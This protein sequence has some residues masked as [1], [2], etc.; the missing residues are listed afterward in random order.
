MHIVEA[1]CHTA[2]TALVFASQLCPRVHESAEQILRSSPCHTAAEVAHPAYAATG[3]QRGCTDYVASELDGL[4]RSGDLGRLAAEHRP[5][6]AAGLAALL[7]AKLQVIL[8]S[9]FENPPQP[10]GTCLTLRSFISY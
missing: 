6:L 8:K 1:P 5:A 2:S 7:T 3:L 9:K 10:V 4:V